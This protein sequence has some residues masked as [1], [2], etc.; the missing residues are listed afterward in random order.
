MHFA[1]KAVSPKVNTAYM[2]PPISQFTADNSAT[3]GLSAPALALAM[4]AALA[5]WRDAG[6]DG[7]FA[8]AP[9]DWLAVARPNP[10]PKAAAVEK[11]PLP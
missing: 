4:E 2:V 11:P 5:W 3:P 9:Q 10:T 1:L 7:D 6:V 8:D